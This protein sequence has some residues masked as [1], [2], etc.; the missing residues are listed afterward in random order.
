MTI[1]IEIQH[2]I[3]DI[4]GGRHWVRV[5]SVNEDEP[6]GI[7]CERVE[8]L[9]KLVANPNDIRAVRITEEVIA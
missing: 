4:L 2:N 9:Q 7:F 8:K 5:E 6:V 1:R 3:R